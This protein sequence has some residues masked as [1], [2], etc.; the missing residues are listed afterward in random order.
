MISVDPEKLIDNG[1]N[2]N[3]IAT[4]YKETCSELRAEMTALGNSWKGNDYNAATSELATLQPGLDAIGE[5]LIEFARMLKETGEDY[6]ARIAQN[7][8]RFN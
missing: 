1:E 6:R 3:G 5:C 8:A 7:A 2:L 4:L